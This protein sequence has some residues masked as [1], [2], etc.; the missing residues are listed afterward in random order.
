MKCCLTTSDPNTRHVLGQ[1]DLLLVHSI[2]V[3]DMSTFLSKLIKINFACALL[4]VWFHILIT[5]QIRLTLLSTCFPKVPIKS[6]YLQK[7]GQCLP[8]ILV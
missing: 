2:H 4:T 1:I 8:N 3:L 6:L 7:L 5:C